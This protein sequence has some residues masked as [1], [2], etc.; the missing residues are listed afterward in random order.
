LTAH[1]DDE[2][3]S[4]AKLSDPLG[5][6]IK[7][8]EENQLKSA[9]ALALHKNEV[10]KQLKEA[11]RTLDARVHARTAELVET[12]ARLME[13]VQEH[14]KTAA[15]L[16]DQTRRNET[17]LHTAMEGFWITNPDGLIQEMNA[18]AAS[19]LG[20]PPEELIGKSVYDYEPKEHRGLAAH[21]RK[22]VRQGSGGYEVRLLH[23]EGNELTLEFSTNFIEMGDQSFLFSFFSDITKK[24]QMVKSL[25]EREA[26][27]KI[28]TQNLKEVNT[29]LK[30]LLKKRDSDR[31]EFEEKVMFNVKEMIF[32]YIK[33]LR[34][35]ELDEKQGIYLT[36]LESNLKDIISPFSPKLTSRHYK[37][38]KSELQIAKLVRMG[39]TSKEIAE[40]MGLSRRTIESHRD[41]I[42][43]KIG[44]DSRKR[45]LRTFLMSID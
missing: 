16:H 36:I 7:P 10:D 14:K 25:K 12:N 21:I 45:N 2:H 6:I 13:E 9:I 38:T 43:K 18:S 29:A 37:L 35:L 1:A 44:L 33:K 22:V 15:A 40:L 8:F 19:I 41:R 27:L 11:N 32:P 17:I 5:Y 23:K 31:T 42:R 39:I 20:Y 3:I 4:R 26:E 30:A 28:K 24:S 34:E